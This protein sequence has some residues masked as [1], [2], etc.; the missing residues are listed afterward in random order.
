VVPVIA[1]RE[2]FGLG[3]VAPTID[4]RVVIAQVGERVIGLLV[5]SARE[6]IRLSPEQIKEPPPMVAEHTAGLV[7]AIA[8]VGARMV[9]LVDVPTLI[10]EEQAHGE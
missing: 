2:R 1:L 3:E 7:R 8:H 9:M 6:V 5:D 4:T 10:G